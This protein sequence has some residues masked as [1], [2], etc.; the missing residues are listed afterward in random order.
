MTDL[1]SDFGE[2]LAPTRIDPKT[3]D[4][5]NKL[6]Y[7]VDF[8]D[9]MER[10][11]HQEFPPDVQ[12]FSKDNLSHIE[13]MEW[14]RTVETI[15]MYPD[16]D[17]LAW[18]KDYLENFLIQLKGE[19]ILLPKEF[20]P[21]FPEGYNEP[22]I[23]LDTETTGLNTVI[24]YGYDGKLKPN[25]KLVGI[26]VAT[27]DIKGYYL[28]IRNTTTDG[29][30]NWHE[31]AV[32][33]FLDDLHQQM[34]VAYHNAQFDREVIAIAG[35]TKFRE[36]PFFFDTQL[37]DFFQDVNDKEHKLKVL[38]KIILGRKMI[39]ITEL[40]TQKVGKGK[41]KKIVITFDRLPATTALVYASTDAI[42]CYGLFKY[43]SSFPAGTNT[44]QDQHIVLQVDHKMVDVLRNLY[45]SGLPINLDYFIFAAKDTIQRIEI[46][47]ET[48]DEYVG[49]HIE[50]GSPAVI[51]QLLF[52]E[53]N[54]PILEGEEKGKLGFYST[55]EEILEKLHELYPDIPILTM[56]VRLRKMTGTLSKI[57]LK[58]IINCY[59][60]A[61]LP[62]TR[63]QLQY[64]QTVIPTG[65]LA[66]SSSKG[67]ERIQVKESKK[68]HV[69]S[70]KYFQGS[71]DCG[72]NS[73]GI[74]NPPYRMAKAKRISQIP[75]EAGIDVAQPYFEWVERFLLK[76]IGDI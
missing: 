58:A 27:S 51:S 36:Y 62:Y 12:F 67:R 60:D 26:S 10:N 2:P 25:V 71:G 35:V 69:I 55:K 45:R 3:L 53:Y 44:F 17:D 31:E 13:G 65:R 49:R 34:V 32:I 19:S 21:S 1:F 11:P 61:L 20:C 41:D 63:V 59:T 72:L 33:G 76:A 46:L 66:S 6:R 43:Y 75:T 24:Q 48:I 22:F 50:M 56:I 70:H 37:L 14:L 30:P 4:V 7:L 5:D 54:I 9:Y 15:L 16:S 73:Q 38:S 23:A 8:D 42:N 64:S 39:D 29:I 74:N 28:P 57:F 68:T 47:K 52:E 40:F 18:Q